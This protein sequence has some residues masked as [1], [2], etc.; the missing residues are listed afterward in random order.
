MA[1]DVGNGRD[2]RDIAVTARSMIEHH[3]TDCTQFRA[4]LREDLKEFRA[5]MKKLMW[6]MA[7]V[8]GGIIILGHGLDFITSLLHK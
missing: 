8:L 4:D 3:M 1:D 6:Y 2:T 7:L 5:D